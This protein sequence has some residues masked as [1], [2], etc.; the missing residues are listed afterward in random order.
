M[1]HLG[2]GKLLGVA[3]GADSDSALGVVSA[4]YAGWVSAVHAFS[5]GGG[6]VQH[7][8]SKRVRSLKAC[9]HGFG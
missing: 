6:P 9:P 8:V 4:V 7:R 3:S 5:V 2:Q 1:T